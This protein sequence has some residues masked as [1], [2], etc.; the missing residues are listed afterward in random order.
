MTTTD[1][2]ERDVAAELLAETRAV[3]HDALAANRAVAVRSMVKAILDRHEPPPSPFARLCA[4]KTVEAA[5]RTVLDEL[6]VAPLDAAPEVSTTEPTA[7]QYEAQ[8]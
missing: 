1:D 3:V 5:V 2:D 6:G 4:E 8:G 7:E